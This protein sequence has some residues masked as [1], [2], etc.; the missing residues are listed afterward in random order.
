[1][2]IFVNE[3]QYTKM[4]FHYH[5]TPIHYH[6]QGAGPVIV[7]L[8]G[9]LESSS[10]WQKIAAVLAKKKYHTY[11]RPSRVWAKWYA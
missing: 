5:N 9:F 1:M 11:D 2:A 3:L 7:M 6:K 10:M 8:H 4:I